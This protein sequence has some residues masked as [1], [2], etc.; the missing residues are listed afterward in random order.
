[1]VGETAGGRPRRRRARLHVRQSE[2]RRRQDPPGRRPGELALRQLRPR[3]DLD[4]GAD[5][6]AGQFGDLEGSAAAAAGARDD[7][8]GS[9]DRRH[10]PGR[11]PGDKTILG[12][13]G[14]WDGAAL[15]D[16]LVEHPATA[17]RLAGRV[18]GLLLGDGAVP[19]GTIEALADGL[20]RRRLDVGWAVE[21][22]LRSRTFFDDGQLGTRVVGPV[23]YVVGAPRALEALEPP[24]STLVLAD[25][26]A[27]LGQDLFYPPNVG[28]WPGGRGWIST[29]SVI[30]RANYAAALAGGDGVGR[31]P[32]DALGFARR[33]G[34]GNSSA[35]SVLA[36]AHSPPTPKA[37][38]KRNAASCQPLRA[39]ADRPVHAEYRR[40]VYVIVRLRPNRSLSM[41]N[42]TP[43]RA[44][45]SKKAARAMLFQKAMAPGVAELPSSAGIASFM[46][47]T[48]TCPSKTSKIQPSDASVRASHW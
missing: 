27:R 9:A 38:R 20:R 47:A 19:G 14:P 18:C 21:T 3:L 48:K 37:A 44:P 13:T 46:L 12:R 31:P 8:A 7:A 15:L 4:H 10:I 32:V 39:N 33:H 25:W 6:A 2:P 40:I 16:A 5:L 36:T 43:P 17:E 11:D 24:P 1:V 45:P 26:A 30:G 41:P 23:Q 42:S 35:T 28:G 29:R 34:R 22:V